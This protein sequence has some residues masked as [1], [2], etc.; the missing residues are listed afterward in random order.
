MKLQVFIENDIVMN[1]KGNYIRLQEVRY[2]FFDSFDNVPSMFSQHI[3]D[4]V[5]LIL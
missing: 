5:R 1:M 3:Q 2:L 4:P